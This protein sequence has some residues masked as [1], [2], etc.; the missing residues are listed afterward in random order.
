M[1]V[2]FRSFSRQHAYHVYAMR[3]SKSD[4]DQ[5]SS[6]IYHSSAGGSDVQDAVEDQPGLIYGTGMS[7]ATKDR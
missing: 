5:T 1:Q 2:F 7:N 6:F 4:E 3:C